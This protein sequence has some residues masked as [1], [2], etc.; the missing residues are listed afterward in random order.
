MSVVQDPSAVWPPVWP[1]VWIVAGPTASGK[2]A[3]ALA[4]AQRVNGTIINVDSMQVYREIPVITAQPSAED[5]TEVP[6][7]L[8]GYVSVLTRMTA[9]DWARQAVLAIRDVQSQGRQ[10]ILVG[11]SGLYLKTLVEGLSPMPPVAPAIRA[12]V[13]NLYEVLG[14]VRFHEALRAL[15]PVTA[16]RLHPTDRQRCIRAREVY[17]ASGQPLSY[18]QAQEKE[19]V[20][21][22]FNYRMVLLLP[23]REWLYD[24]INKRFDHMVAAGALDEART[25]Q[26]LNADPTLTGVQALGL[27]A[28]MDYL[29]KRLTLIEAIERGQTQSRQFAKRQ[30]TWFRGQEL[31]NVPTLMLH[32]PQ[33]VAQALSFLSESR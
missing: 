9:L 33:G 15:D 28:L 27:S 16:A 2:S 11:G 7:L 4:L 18:W 29:E 21:G 22:D 20:G 12:Q 30:Y 23:D 8:Y 31:C 6:H 32:D 1:P 19:A 5:L 17:E 14:P 10:P 13:T 3:L 25:V 26:S 24:K